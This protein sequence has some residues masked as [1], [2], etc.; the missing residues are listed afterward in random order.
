MKSPFKFSLS[1]KHYLF[2]FC[3]ASVQSSGVLAAETNAIFNPFEQQCSSVFSPFEN[4]DK[5]KITVNSNENI[6]R[7]E[8]ADTHLGL[9]TIALTN[10]EGNVVYTSEVRLWDGMTVIDLEMEDLEKGTFDLKFSSNQGT[11]QSKF[12]RI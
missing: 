10:E 9:G 12:T 11:F 2:L 6:V 1:A 4:G 7:I 3:L 8:I 5:I